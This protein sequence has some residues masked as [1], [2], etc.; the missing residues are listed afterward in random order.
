MNYLSF[1]VLMNLFLFGGKQKVKKKIVLSLLCLAIL[2]NGMTAFAAPE[3]IYDEEMGYTIFDP[4][5]FIQHA[6]PYTLM[7]TGMIDGSGNQLVDTATLYQEYRKYCENIEY[8][9]PYDFSNAVTGKNVVPVFYGEGSDEFI[10][11]TAIPD[12]VLAELAKGPTGERDYY[13][14]PIQD[15]IYWNQDIFR[16]DDGSGLIDADGNGI[17][18]RDVI[19]G[20]G[21]IDLDYN[22]IDDRIEH[23]ILTQQIMEIKN[24]NYM[25]ESEKQEQIQIETERLTT[26]SL[27]CEHGILSSQPCLYGGGGEGGIATANGGACKI[28]YPW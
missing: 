3:L 2:G 28:C 13:D 11:V 12:A 15:F 26:S 18:D 14:N 9:S 8:V 6:E 1:F 7:N 20:L 25:S 27:L 21:F 24:N 16:T 23:Y 5:Y 22:S 19:N 10:Y 4:T 17:D